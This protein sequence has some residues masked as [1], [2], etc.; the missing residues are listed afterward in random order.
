[1]T[2]LDP[3]LPLAQ[4][5]EFEVGETFS[6]HASVDKNDICCESDNVFIKV[7]DSDAA[8]VGRSYTDVVVTVLAGPD[9]VDNISPDPLDR[10]HAPSSC[11][12]PSLSPK[13]CNLLLV[14]CYDMLEGHEIDCMNSL[15]T[16]K[17]NDPSLDPYSLYLRNMPA[18]TLFTIAFNHSTDFSKACDKF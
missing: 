1:M 10:F 17:G 16:F 2:L 5:T 6:V 13:P 8:P 11:S 3:P 18:K 14:A 9:M 12:L 4:S 7:H 15:G